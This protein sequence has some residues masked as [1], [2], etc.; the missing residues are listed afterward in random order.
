MIKELK[1]KSRVIVAFAMGYEEKLKDYKEEIHPKLL[2]GLNKQSVTESHFLK[3]F[4]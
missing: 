1:K 3:Y 2:E 4:P